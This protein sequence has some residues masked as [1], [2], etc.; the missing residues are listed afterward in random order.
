MGVLK[1]ISSKMR[2]FIWRF[3][4]ISWF[5][6]ESNFEKSMISGNVTLIIYTP[7]P[8]VLAS[9]IR[10]YANLTKRCWIITRSNAENIC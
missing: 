10:I 4:N 2:R 6:G 7:H 3:H 9:L 1:Q 8:H 5:R